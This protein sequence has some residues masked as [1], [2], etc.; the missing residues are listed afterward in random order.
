MVSLPANASPIIR[1][2]GVGT[3]FG[4]LLLIFL[5]RPGFAPRAVIVFNSVLGAARLGH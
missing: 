3:V 4:S 1:A 5:R 2:Y